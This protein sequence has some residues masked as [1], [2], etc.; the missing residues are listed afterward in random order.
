M[1]FLHV[2]PSELSYRRQSMS[3]Y[4]DLVKLNASHAFLYAYVVPP[5][6][7]ILS[8]QDLLA[9]LTSRNAAIADQQVFNLKLSTEV[10]RMF[11]QRCCTCP[12]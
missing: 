6:R 2:K 12:C 8:K 11:R 1:L 7:D 5:L 4:C 10:T 9:N 3:G